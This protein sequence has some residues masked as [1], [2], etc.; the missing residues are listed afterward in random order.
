MRSRDARQRIQELVETGLAR[1]AGP[2]ETKGL[3]GGAR[4]DGG[5]GVELAELTREGLREAAAALGL[6]LGTAERLHGFAGGGPAIRAGPV[7]A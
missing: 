7:P 2:D 6:S 1:W 3:A 4:T 5:T